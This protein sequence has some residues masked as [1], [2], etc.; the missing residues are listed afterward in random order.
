M[1][2]DL[3]PFVFQNL[4]TASVVG[5]SAA[6]WVELVEVGAANLD[7]FGVL[8]IGGGALLALYCVALM[9]LSIVRQI[10]IS[11]M[12]MDAS[13]VA[14][15]AIAFVLLDLIFVRVLSYF[16]GFGLSYPFMIV[17]IAFAATWTLPRKD[18]RASRSQT[19]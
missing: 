6:R 17:L 14:V 1:Y 4:L 13:P 9:L 18:R 7:P 3:E 5:W 15:L 10:P 16:S 19:S 2:R 12:E 11:E 8:M